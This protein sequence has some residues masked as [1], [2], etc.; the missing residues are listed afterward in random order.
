LHYDKNV[1]IQLLELIFL[2]E[3]RKDILLFLR[4][5][6]KTIKQIKTHLNVGAVAILPQIKKLREN[7]LILKKKEVYILSPLGIAVT[8][9]MKPIADL[10]KLFGTQ[11]D[12]WVDHKIECIPIP[13]LRRIGELS[14]CKFSKPPDKAHLFE[15]HREFIG[16]LEKSEKIIGIASIFH[17]SYPYFI[18][19]CLK[20]RKP[21]S[22]IITF[23]VYERVKEEF[24]DIMKE[25]LNY[26]NGTLYICR[27][28]I[29]F[30]YVVTDR[31]LSVSLPFSDGTYDHQREILCFD[32]VALQWG[33]DLFDYYRD[34]SE[35][36][37]NI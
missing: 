4:D 17:P 33:E 10:L 5:G 12:F 32:P 25:S 35:K 16:N 19:D 18:L 36:V 30:S 6:P 8:G 22:L 29:E 2:S 11:N 24:E 7:F 3:K 14:K 23:S 37:T 20:M 27:K 28:E 26:E 21:I 13:F 1:D 15:P 31:F 9:N 34:M